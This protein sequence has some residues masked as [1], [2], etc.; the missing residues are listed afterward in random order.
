[1]NAKKRRAIVYIAGRLIVRQEYGV[2]YDYSTRTYTYMSGKVTPSNVTVF[3]H[4]R[5]CRITGSGTANEIMIFDYGSDQ[6]VRLRIR[7]NR[8]EG[9]DRETGK[10]IL[11][12]VDG[13]AITVR[14]HEDSNTYEYSL[15]T[16]I[17]SL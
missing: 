13:T 5:D 1:M 17:P 11:G 4:D 8:F 16:R 14:D 9:H 15:Y 6:Y 12:S 3:D 7:G 10:D 2:I